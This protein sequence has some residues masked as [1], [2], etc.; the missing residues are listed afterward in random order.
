MADSKSVRGLYISIGIITT[1]VSLNFTINRQCIVHVLSS[2][3][4]QGIRVW[5]RLGQEGLDVDNQ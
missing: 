5:R 4:N 2:H 1:I 3:E